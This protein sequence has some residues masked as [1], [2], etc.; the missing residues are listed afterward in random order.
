MP[1]DPFSRAAFLFQ[2]RSKTSL[3]ALPYDGN[4][5]WLAKKRLSKET[6]QW[7]PDANAA[8]LDVQAHL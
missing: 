5:F 8:G 1:E 4:A 6:F 3:V 2:T 7:W